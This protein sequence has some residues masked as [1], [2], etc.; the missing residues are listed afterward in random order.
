MLGWL[1]SYLTS[2]SH[3][4]GRRRGGAEGSG[5]RAEAG[6]ASTQQIST[7]HVDKQV[8][9]EAALDDVRVFR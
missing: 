8:Q 1:T 9:F 7:R 6:R 3:E 5:V 4:P 2:S